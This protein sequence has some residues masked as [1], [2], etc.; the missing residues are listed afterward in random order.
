[1][2]CDH[3]M[4][5]V[6]CR[7]KC[8]TERVNCSGKWGYIALTC[9]QQKEC[10]FILHS[11]K[12][13]CHTSPLPPDTA[14]GTRMYVISKLLLCGVVMCLWICTGHRFTSRH[15]DKHKDSCADKESHLLVGN[16]TRDKS[17]QI[18]SRQEKLS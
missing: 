18:E 14:L 5:K 17:E 6:C 7:V 4:C 16:N 3:D 11:L 1:M 9:S 10:R 13:H 2:K 12:V 15:M 8:R